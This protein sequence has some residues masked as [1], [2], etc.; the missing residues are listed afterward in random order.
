LIV[1]LFKKTSALLISSMLAFFIVLVAVTMIRG[2]DVECGCFDT[3]SHKA[4]WKLILEDAV[5]LFGSIQVAFQR[6]GGNP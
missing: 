4:D 3:F 5:M 2:L 6:K 1:G